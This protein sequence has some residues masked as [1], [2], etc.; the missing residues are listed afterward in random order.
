VA[1]TIGGV[2]TMNNKILA[3]LTVGLMAAPIAAPAQI[4][5][6]DYQ[7]A[8]S[9]GTTYYNNPTPP[10][11]L[12]PQQFAASFTSA[13]FTGNIT[14]SLQ[15]SGSAGGEVLSG[16]VNVT[17]SAG[18]NINLSFGLAALEYGSPPF[19]AFD[20][21]SGTVN[22][23]M[24]NGAITGATMDIT[25]SSYHEPTMFLTIGPTGSATL[26]YL[27]NGTNGPCTQQGA[28]E[29][30]PCTLTAASN[31]AGV[32]QATGAPEID[33]ASAASGLTLLLGGLAVMRGRRKLG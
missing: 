31:S 18:T 3:M 26:D 30:N 4:T 7:S 29:P 11:L 22:L 14:A 32:W 6:L 10:Q 13:P 21:S 25:F 19:L 28:D 2:D 20:G 27:Y 24:S 17:G 8:L 5:T 9:G 15:E 12:T 16:T 1:E 33:P 23:L